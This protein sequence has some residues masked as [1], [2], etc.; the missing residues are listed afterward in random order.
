MR[1]F[2]T[3]PSCLTCARAVKIPTQ[4]TPSFS[5]R[6]KL[7]AM[8]SAGRKRTAMD[9]MERKKISERNTEHLPF[10]FYTVS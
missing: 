3:V 5:L 4:H 7:F 8:L 9:P 6:T 2:A 10:L 1:R